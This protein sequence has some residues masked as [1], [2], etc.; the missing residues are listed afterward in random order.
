MKQLT[1]LLLILFSSVLSKAQTSWLLSYEWD[2]NPTVHELS[3]VEKKESA[4]YI[5]HVSASEIFYQDDREAIEYYMEH[6]IIH[7]NDQEAINEHNKVYMPG[8]RYSTENYVIVE[9]A[10][11]IKPNGEIINLDNGSILEEKE[12]E[13]FIK[14]RFFAL[15][16][17]EVGDEIEYYYIYPKQP[18]TSG[19]YAAMQ[20]HSL[21]R[22]A[23]RI[24]ITPLNL[25]NKFHSFNGFPEMIQDSNYDDRNFF[26]AT[27]KDLPGLPKEKYSD[28]F[29]NR[30][31]VGHYLYRNTYQGSS[32][33]LYTNFSKGVGKL[34]SDVNPKKDGVLKL[35]KKMDIPQSGS[36]DKKI[37]YVEDYIK[38]EFAVLNFNFLGISVNFSKDLKSSIK[39][40][41]FS[42]IYIMQLY[43]SIFNEMGIDYEIVYTSDRTDLRFE[44]DFECYLFLDYLMFYF[45]KTGKYLCPGEKTSRYGYPPFKYVNNNG[46]FIKM[47]TLGGVSSG[48]GKVK[49]MDAIPA[50][51]NL[52]RLEVT[53]HL[54]DLTNAKVEVKREITGYA[55]GF[56]QTM[57]NTLEEDRQQELKEALVKYFDENMEITSMEVKNLEPEDFGEKPLEV[58]AEFRSKEFI[59]KAG[60][61]Y[62]INV[63][64]LIGPQAELYQEGKRET[65]VSNAY[66][67]E[68]IR[69]IVVKIPEGYELVNLDSLNMKVVYDRQNKR[70]LGFISSYEIKGDELIINVDEYYESIEYPVAEYPHFEN[71]INAAADFNKIAILLKKKS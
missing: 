40:G 47:V 29:A 34:V 39:S 63:G 1:L 25:I 26:F 37:R 56:E 69:R 11:V 17:I 35:M 38:K 53:L 54:D 62:L 23:T 51:E 33:D 8:S 36:T 10:R 19:S 18:R 16:G 20:S 12:E 5:K 28:Y 7:L 59:Q 58:E 2:E 64:K 30:G 43:A 52:D 49:F 24:V 13:S 32:F 68:Y 55:A 14:K 57:M 9:E 42:D 65:K 60:S 22:E 31:A 46:Y 45:P 4:V 61:N 44:K 15:E 27:A 67:H 66:N 3:E 70:D 6:V 21:K 71:V 41:L 48:I 50:E